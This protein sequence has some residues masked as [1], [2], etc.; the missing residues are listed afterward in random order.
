MQQPKSTTIVYCQY[1]TI[2]ISTWLP[3]SLI[4]S[5]HVCGQRMYQQLIVWILTNNNHRTPIRV[6]NK[7]QQKAMKKKRT[8]WWTLAVKYAREAP[9]PAMHPPIGSLYSD[10][11]KGC[12][13]PAYKISSSFL[14]TLATITIIQQLLFFNWTTDHRSMRDSRSMTLPKKTKKRKLVKNP[15]NVFLQHQEQKSMMKC[16]RKWS[17][18]VDHNGV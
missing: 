12:I 6:S 4:D 5:P 10:S 13:S 16:R 9:Y 7:T 2:T 17:G 8:W 15:L 11:I 1:D 14:Y 18:S 3:T